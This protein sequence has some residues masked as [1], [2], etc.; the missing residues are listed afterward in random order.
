METRLTK[1]VMSAFAFHSV[2]LVDS[3]TVLSN[4]ISLMMTICNYSAKSFTRNLVTKNDSQSQSTFHHI[5]VPIVV[6]NFTLYYSHANSRAK[7]PS[8]I[9]KLRAKPKIVTS[10][11]KQ[12]SVS[13]SFNTLPE[14]R[15]KLA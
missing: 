5:V 12:V 14:V 15:Y 6:N 13:P 1:V 7:L 4:E 2:L 11:P 9:K 8:T 10:P 3:V